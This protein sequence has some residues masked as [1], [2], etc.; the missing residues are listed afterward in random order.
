MNNELFNS[1]LWHQSM[2]GI[3]AV[4]MLSAH[5][6]RNTFY[7]Y[8]TKDWFNGPSKE[9]LNHIQVIIKFY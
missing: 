4:Q 8:L 6:D 7:N 1:V 5:L 3:N 9:H 2:K